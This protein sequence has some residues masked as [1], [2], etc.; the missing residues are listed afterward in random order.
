M[1]QIGALNANFIY[2]ETNCVHG[3]I[4]FSQ[5]SKLLNCL[6][7]KQTTIAI[8]IAP[9]TSKLSCSNTGLVMEQAYCERR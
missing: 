8:A 5:L 7:L 3:H 4:A 9:L 1:E 2:T 6:S